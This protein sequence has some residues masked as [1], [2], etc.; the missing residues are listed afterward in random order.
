VRG[1]TLRLRRLLIGVL[2]LA[3]DQEPVLA[4]LISGPVG[5]S[6]PETLNASS[7]SAC[8]KGNDEA[9]RRLL[10]GNFVLRPA[11]RTFHL[12]AGRRDADGR[13]RI[14]LQR[15]TM[16]LIIRS[17]SYDELQAVCAPD[18]ESPAS[19]RAAHATE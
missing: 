3:L 11:A 14:R 12:K 15:K 8:S 6:L 4:L 7:D 5:I 13:T 1:L 9:R 2:I 16:S 19:S 18:R 17:I 10:L